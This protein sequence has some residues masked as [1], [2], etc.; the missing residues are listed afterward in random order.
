MLGASDSTSSINPANLVDTCRRCH[1]QATVE[2]AVS[3]AHAP[4]AASAGDRGAATVRRIYTWVIALVIGGML[5]HNLLVF[6]QDM[7]RRWAHHRQHATHQ[8]LNRNETIQ[9]AVLLVTF[10]LLVLTGFAL[11]YDH[12]FWA[13]WLEAIGM[14]EGVRRV[15]HRS[16]AVGMIAA[17]LYHVVYLASRRGREQLA[18]MVPKL[19]DVHEFRQSA[20]LRACMAGLWPTMG[21][22]RALFG[23]LAYYLGRRPAPPHGATFNYAE[24]AEY[25]ALV[26]GTIVM[27]STGL[28]LWF[29]DQLRGPSWFLRVAEAIHLYEAWLAFLAI[30]IWHFFFVMFRP[31]TF[32]LSYTVFTGRMEPGELEEEHP[33]EYR[34]HYHRRLH[35]LPPGETESG[36][37]TG[38]EGGGA[39]SVAVSD[40]AA[41]PAADPETGPR[42]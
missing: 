21:D 35:R 19:R 29:P 22:L 12:T 3:Y 4:R 16:A 10:M 23:T 24:K 18:H 34:A 28:V 11:K 2:F 32:P 39:E 1:K 13:K 36:T 14:S 33:E 9:H 27:A 31:G 5:L 37:E 38:T 42:S 30:V 7:R 40:A 20:R 25:W 6:V 15:V 26:W 8:R 41:A 17:S